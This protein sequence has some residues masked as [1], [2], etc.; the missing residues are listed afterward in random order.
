MHGATIKIIS[1]VILTCFRQEIL[2]EIRKVAIFLSCL[3]RW[4]GNGAHVF[5]CS[6]YYPPDKLAGEVAACS[7]RPLV[8][9]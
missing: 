2:F 5:A 6:L 7:R 1:T 3:A 4:Q 8:L 9:K